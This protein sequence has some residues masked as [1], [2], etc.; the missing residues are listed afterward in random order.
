MLFTSCSSGGTNESSVDSQEMSEPEFTFKAAVTDSPKEEELPVL[1]YTTEDIEAMAL[2]LAGECYDDKPHDK[3]LVCEVILNR[4]S[5]GGFGDTPFEVCS[6]PYQFSGYTN[7]SRPI[8]ENDYEIVYQTLEDWRDN[9][10][11]ALSEWLFFS[12]GENRE[13]IFREEY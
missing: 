8:S 11:Q 13:N 7:Q 3:R 5:H 2:T 12:A 9:D 1:R 4:V 10:Y 6:A